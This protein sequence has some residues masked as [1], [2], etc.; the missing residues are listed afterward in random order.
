MFWQLDDIRN[1]AL[2]SG[3]AGLLKE[4]RRAVS[5]RRGGK[6]KLSWC[7]RC[8]GT[9]RPPLSVTATVWYHTAARAASKS[10]FIFSILWQSVNSQFC[11]DGRRA[12]CSP[13]RRLAGRRRY[14]G[15]QGQSGVDVKNRPAEGTSRG[16]QL[17]K[18]STATERAQGFWLSAQ[19]LTLIS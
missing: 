11:M 18:Q 15:F 1:G 13:A 5:G 8:P 7:R 16:F 10:P 3:D 19:I 9:R 12:C 4:E 6:P 17:K 2:G 14:T